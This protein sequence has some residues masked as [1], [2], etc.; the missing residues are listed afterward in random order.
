MAN[1]ST[2]RDLITKVQAEGNKS[3]DSTED[4]INGVVVG[5]DGF[6]NVLDLIYAEI[7]K[8]TGLMRQ[9]INQLRY[10]SAAMDEMV[11]DFGRMM[12]FQSLRVQPSAENTTGGGTS[13]PTPGQP[14]NPGQGMDISGL[15]GL[16]AVAIGSLVGA[17]KGWIKAIDFFTFGKSTKW[18]ASIEAKFLSIGSK[19]TKVFASGL[20]IVKSGLLQGLSKIGSFLKFDS[21]AVIKVFAKISQLGSYIIAPFV[22]AGKMLGS[23]FKVG[24]KVG[25]VLGFMSN[26]FGKFGTILKATSGIVSKLA[27]PVMIIM[28]AFDTIKGAIDGFAEG[29]IMG[30]LEGAITGFFNSLIFG[31]LDLIKNMVSWVVGMFGFENAAATLDSFSFSDIFSMIVG[32]LFD[33]VSGIAQGVIDQFKPDGEFGKAWTYLT[34]LF[35]NLT[36]TIKQKFADISDF[37]GSIPDRMWIYAQEMWVD[38]T[39]KLKKGFILFGDWFASIPARIKYMALSTIREYDPTGYLVSEEAV[40][41][42]KSA[43]DNRSSN[44]NEKLAQV[45]KEAETQMQSINAQKAALLNSNAAQNSGNVTVAP[46]TNVVNGGNSSSV[47]SNSTTIINAAPHQSLNAHMPI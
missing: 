1:N 40:A 41:E 37:V 25:G 3:R 11:E 7:L 19:I 23:L 10:Q 13:A 43:V 24:Q 15:L 46:Q 29:G 45:D 5:F 9:T 18:I 21:P 17:F 32:A 38:I 31:P 22:E 20:E 4:T 6:A 12:E 34:G 2:M 39:T 14:G 33:A 8:H 28:T 26:A 42:A 44:T 47:N 27:F 16:S 35:G 36:S 30:A